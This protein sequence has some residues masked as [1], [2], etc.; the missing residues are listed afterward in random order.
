MR[1]AR[2]VLPLVLLAF[3]A[4]TYAETKMGIVDIRTALFSTKSAKKFTEDLKKDFSDDEKKVR[5]AQEGAK[6]IKDRLE[7]DGSL[8]SDAER[9]RLAGDFESKAKDFNFLKNK[10]ETG[11]STRQQSFLQENK[12]LVDQGLEEILKEQKLDLI[13]PREAVI[14]SAPSLDI[15]QALIDK[16]NAKQKN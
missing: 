9:T 3:S 10:L 6:K 15:T 16:L 8:M 11:I 2:Y 1:L 12:P 7:K 5:E 13:L 14:Y 4:A